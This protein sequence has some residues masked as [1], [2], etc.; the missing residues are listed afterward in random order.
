MQSSGLLLE[1]NSATTSF[2]RFSVYG[3]YSY[4][5]LRQ[6]YHHGPDKAIQGYCENSES[7]EEGEARRNSALRL[8][9]GEN[10][11]VYKPGQRCGELSS[12]LYFNMVMY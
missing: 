9:S 11:R 3:S 12:S 4:L 1:L 2:N 8:S 6:Y 10:L 7:E 5:Y